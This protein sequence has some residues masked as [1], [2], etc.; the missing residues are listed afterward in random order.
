MPSNITLK[1]LINSLY[2]QTLNYHLIKNRLYVERSIN[3]VKRWVR[4]I[5]GI[6]IESDTL[7]AAWQVGDDEAKGTSGDIEVSKKSNENDR[8]HSVKSFGEIYQTCKNC[9]GVICIKLLEYIISFSWDS[10]IVHNRT[11]VKLFHVFVK[12][13]LP[14]SALASASS[15]SFYSDI[16][17]RNRTR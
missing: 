1:V 4:E 3:V 13:R 17:Y 6:T 2:E 15:S 5:T 12:Y 9:R 14:I 16:L 11:S 8:G 10:E 7:L